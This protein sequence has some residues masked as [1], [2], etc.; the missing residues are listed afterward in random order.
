MLLTELT[1]HSR[2]GA[3]VGEAVA[4]NVTAATASH[5]GADAECC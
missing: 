4:G 1:S 3:Y 5:L 2:L